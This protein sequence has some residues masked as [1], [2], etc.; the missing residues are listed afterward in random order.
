MFKKSIALV[1]ALAAFNAHALVAGD[2]AFTS[3]N[4]DEDGFAMVALTSIAANTS[5]Y[6][7]D[8]EWSGGNVGAGGTFNTG[9]SY[10]QWLSGGQDIAAGTVVRFNSIEKTTLSASVGNLSRVSVSGSSNYGLANSNET[11]YAYQGS[12]AT[13]PTAFIAAVTNGDFA[14]DGTLAGTGLVQGVSAIRLNANVPTA[15]PDFGEYSGARSGQTSFAAYLPMINS[16]ANWQ[17]DTT[18]G[19]YASAVPNTGAFTVAVV[20]EPESFALALAGVAVVALS[21]RRTSR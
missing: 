5:V 3:F 7:G 13:A 4:A 14:V 6:F 8:N 17:V 15:S 12:S 2:L 11:L 20:P 18:N 10:L 21:R 1:A 9:E 19:S 16:P